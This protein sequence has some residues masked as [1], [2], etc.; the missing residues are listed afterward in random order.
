MAQGTPPAS[1]ESRDTITDLPGATGSR[2]RPESRRRGL[3]ATDTWAGY[4]SHGRQQ[5]RSRHH[6]PPGT[7]ISAVLAESSRCPR[8]SWHDRNR[9]LWPGGPKWTRHLAAFPQA[10]VGREVLGWANHGYAGRSMRAG[11]PRHA[12]P[13]RTVGTRREWEQP[14][15]AAHRKEWLVLV[16]ALSCRA[17]LP[18]IRWAP[19]R[20]SAFPSCP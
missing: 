11:R 13:R 7:H 17:S 20:G 3:S 12:F 6:G 9:E 15:D 16:R 2:K 19:V 14:R 8:H 10:A 4:P 5:H 18:L 1:R